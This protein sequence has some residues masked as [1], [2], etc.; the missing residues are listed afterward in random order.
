MNGGRT[1]YYT[2]AEIEKMEDDSV[3]L[4]HLRSLFR[5]LYKELIVVI[6]DLLENID[7]E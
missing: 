3:N 2:L 5:T 4:A 1:P 7:D 6:P